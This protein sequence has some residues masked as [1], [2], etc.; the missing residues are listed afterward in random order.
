M[1]VKGFTLLEVLIALVIIS[2][3]FLA[4]LR[5]SAVN[6]RSQRE[7]DNLAIAVSAAESIMKEIIASG[8]PESVIE[9]GD[10]EEGYFSGFRW[11]KK[12]EVVEFPYIEELKLVTVEVLWGDRGH[13]ELRTVVSR[14]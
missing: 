14:H 8:Y 10:F 2:T 7:A 5:T 9:E 4:L 6:L 11:K 1:R 12:V 3:A 13:Y